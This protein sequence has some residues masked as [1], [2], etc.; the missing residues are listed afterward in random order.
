MEKEKLTLFILPDKFAICHLDE[1]SYVPYWATENVSFSCLTRT[2]NELSIVCPEN[3]IPGGILSEKGWRAI[4][5]KGPLGFVMPGIVS[6]LSTPLA[7]AEISIFYISTYETD[8]L[9]VK[10]E[11]LDKTV[12]ILSA[13]CNIKQE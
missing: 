13:F 10:E 4:R 1:K 2:E 11:N 12:K 5:V 8:Y 9:L 7:E 6:S 3:D